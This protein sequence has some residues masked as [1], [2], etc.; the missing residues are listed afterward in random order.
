[1]KAEHE[2]Q[3]ELK[4]DLEDLE[5]EFINVESESELKSDYG[6]ADSY[7]ESDIL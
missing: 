1:V 7:Y 2:A 5:D 6:I 4:I 3:E